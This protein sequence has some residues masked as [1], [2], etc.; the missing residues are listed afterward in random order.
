MVLAGLNLAKT[1]GTQN[2]LLHCDS[3]LVTSQI[4]GEYMARDELMA[5]YLSKVQQSISHF[6][7]VKVE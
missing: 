6:N 7:I 2:L 1:L 4:N 3:L 5:A